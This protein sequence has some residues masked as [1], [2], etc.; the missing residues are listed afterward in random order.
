MDY[1]VSAQDVNLLNG[2][3]TD[4]D[5]LGGTPASLD[6]S[7]W[8][9]LVTDELLNILMASAQTPSETK[10]NQVAIAIQSGLLNYGIDTGAANAYVVAYEPVISSLSAGMMLRFKATSANTGATTLNVGT[11]ALPVISMAGAA[12]QGGEIVAGSTVTVIYIGATGFVLLAASGGAVPV[13][14]ASKSNHAVNLGQFVFSGNANAGF[15]RFP[16]GTLIQFGTASLSGTTVTVTQSFP[17]TFP[18]GNIRC[19]CSDIGNTTW[20]AAI[21]A[22]TSSTYQIFVCPFSANSGSLVAKNSQAT[23]TWIAVGN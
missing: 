4:G 7:V 3:F 23:I 21:N 11:G 15:I 19:V 10:S 9:N 1:P 18:V 5:P 16:N 13:A 17:T 8:A 20:A 12:L 22:L 2:K 14:A 6:P